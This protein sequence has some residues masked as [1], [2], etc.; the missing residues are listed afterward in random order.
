[1]LDAKPA[2]AGSATRARWGTDAT[3]AGAMDR[4]RTEHRTGSRR[5]D[6]MQEHARWDI[7][8]CGVYLWGPGA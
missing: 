8:Q 6:R 4:A 1:M 3:K 7:W 2:A 5:R